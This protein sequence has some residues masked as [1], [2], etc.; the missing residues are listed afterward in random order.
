MIDSLITSQTRI[1]LLLKF[2][3]NP[4]T[5]GYLRQLASEFNEST[6]SIRVELNKLSEARILLLETTGRNKIYYANTKHPLFDDIRNI[7]LK[8]TGIDKVISDILNN[9][10]TI[11]LAFVRGDYAVGKDTGLIDLVFV[12][13]AI[14]PEE[15]ER[16]K[17]KTEKLIMR[18]ISVLILSE[19]EYMKLKDNF[20]K[21]PMLILLNTLK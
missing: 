10:G 6:N 2:F 11:S 20:S 18:K 7:V 13:E 12:S 19:D 8:S 16:I 14:N 9:L 3:L 1:N 5:K 4:D 21:E 15:L 17:L